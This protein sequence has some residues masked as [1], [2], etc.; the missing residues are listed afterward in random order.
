MSEKHKYAVTLF[1][2][3]SSD[4]EA[5]SADEAAS[6]AKKRLIAGDF[7]PEIKTVSV[8][9]KTDQGDSHSEIPGDKIK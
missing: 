8:D 6:I 4:I 3:S 1:I 9:W 2:A 5:E 7:N